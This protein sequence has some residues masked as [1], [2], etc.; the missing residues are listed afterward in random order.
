MDKVFIPNRSGHNFE[1]AKVINN[2]PY[3]LVF[4]TEGHIRK[5]QVNQIYRQF[6]AAMKDAGPNDYFITSSLGILNVIGGAILARKTGRLN[7]LLYRDGKYDPRELDIDAML[8]G[9]TIPEDEENI[10]DKENE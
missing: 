8:V 4:I 7:L 2:K 5:N 6:A 10:E 3:E 1:N 9:D